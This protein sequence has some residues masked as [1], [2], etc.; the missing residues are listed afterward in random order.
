MITVRGENP[1]RPWG[2]W[3]YDSGRTAAKHG[4]FHLNEG[5]S[6]GALLFCY[7]TPAIPL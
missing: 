5:K 3:R 4:L 7:D 6:G 1:Q 2:Q